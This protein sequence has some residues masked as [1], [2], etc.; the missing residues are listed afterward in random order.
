MVNLSPIDQSVFCSFNK[1]I[2]F[3]VPG[4]WGRHG[5]TFIDLK[6]VKK[7]LFKRCVDHSLEKRCRAEACCKIF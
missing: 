6:K 3:P 7:N 1:G 4:G 5:S 2:I